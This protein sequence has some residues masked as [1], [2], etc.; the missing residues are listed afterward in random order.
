MFRARE[1]NLLFIIKPFSFTHMGHLFQTQMV[2]IFNDLCDYHHNPYITTIRKCIV[3]SHAFFW[4][5][6]MF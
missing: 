6:E 5:H 3:I 1:T 2:E 4:N